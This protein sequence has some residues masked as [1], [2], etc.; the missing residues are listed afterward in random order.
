MRIHNEAIAFNEYFDGWFTLYKKHVYKQ[1]LNHYKET[2][3][4]IS[5][6]F[7]DKAIQNITRNDYQ[8]FLNDY[9]E[10]YSKEVMLKVH[11]HIKAAVEHAI[12]DEIIRINFAKKVIVTG[13]PPKNKGEKHLEF[14]E[15]EMLYA[16]TG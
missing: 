4:Y 8:K 9:G 13:N 11:G 6:H 10:K 14:F 1:T 7:A 2:L 5:E 12:E 15:S 3:R 16:Y